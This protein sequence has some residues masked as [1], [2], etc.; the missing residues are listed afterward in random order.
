MQKE[1]LWRLT[2]VLLAVAISISLSGPALADDTPTFGMDRART[3]AVSSE[4]QLYRGYALYNPTASYYPLGLGLQSYST[5][6][7]YTASDGTHV[8]LAYAW[9]GQNGYLYGMREAN[10]G[11]SGLWSGP[12]CLVPLTGTRP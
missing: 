1:K 3:R 10:N 12:V 9:E 7:G 5:P 6:T 2:T 4:A 11:I 8:V